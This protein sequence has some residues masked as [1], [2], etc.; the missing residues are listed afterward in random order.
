MPAEKLSFPP[1]LP[2]SASRV[3]QQCDYNRLIG[4]IFGAFFFFF[5]GKSFAQCDVD[6]HFHG[7][8]CRPPG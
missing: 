2:L 5:S 7:R 6:I 8:E 1:P 3:H 4:V